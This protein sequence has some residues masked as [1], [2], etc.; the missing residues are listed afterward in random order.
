M[1]DYRIVYDRQSKKFILESRTG[2]SVLF[3]E[4]FETLTELLQHL[5]K[6]VRQGR[7]WLHP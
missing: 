1:F 2:E 5:E 6:E 4:T 7:P 3:A